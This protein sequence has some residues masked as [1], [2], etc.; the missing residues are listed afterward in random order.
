MGRPTASRSDTS[1]LGS[2]GSLL[3]R[4]SLPIS[5]E[6]S[7]FG[8]APSCRV[9]LTSKVGSAPGEPATP[10]GAT[11]VF[12]IRALNG[13]VSILASRSLKLG[14]LLETLSNRSLASGRLS[15]K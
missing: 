5:P 14:L 10:V 4:M 11:G 15:S 12:S 2:S 13:P 6:A 1:F 3:I 8:V 9:T 7:G